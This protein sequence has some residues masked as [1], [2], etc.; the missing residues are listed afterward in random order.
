MGAHLWVRVAE[1]KW[2]AQV[3]GAAAETMLR[4]SSSQAL[5]FEPE[6]ERQ[7]EVRG[8]LEPGWKGAIWTRYP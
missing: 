5:W 8:R 6:L 1:A 2:K 7:I 4:R 3:S